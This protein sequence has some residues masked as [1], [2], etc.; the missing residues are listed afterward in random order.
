METLIFTD[1][2]ADYDAL[3]AQ[4]KAPKPV[5]EA[6]EED[7]EPKLPKQHRKGVGQ[8]IAPSAIKQAKR[9][10]VAAATEGDEAVSKKYQQLAAKKSKQGKAAGGYGN[11][12]GW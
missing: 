4:G 12:G 11:F 10:A 5:I 6:A 9:G 3:K 7:D 1:P 2:F 8:F